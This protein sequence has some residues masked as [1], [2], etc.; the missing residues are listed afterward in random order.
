MKVK[1]ILRKKGEK[2]GTQTAVNEHEKNEKMFLKLKDEMKT[3]E[4]EKKLSL[5]SLR[6]SVFAD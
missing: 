1:V 6:Q 3:W 4:N 5:V 2:I